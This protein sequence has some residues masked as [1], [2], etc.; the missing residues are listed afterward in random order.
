MERHSGGS[1]MTAPRWPATGLPG[2]LTVLSVPAPAVL[3]LPT[4]LQPQHTARA[5][6]VMA[7]ILMKSKKATVMARAAMCAVVSWIYIIL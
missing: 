6:R 7:L 2:G 1:P 5:M 4:G 3:P